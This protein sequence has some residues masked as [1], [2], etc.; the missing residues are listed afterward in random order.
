MMRAVQEQAPPP[1]GRQRGDYDGRAMR[2]LTTDR[3]T[4]PGGEL[5]RT[6]EIGHT[7]IVTLRTQPLT[8][9]PFTWM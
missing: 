6:T 1:V 3:L 2:G 9:L 5:A 8:S 4:I 7:L